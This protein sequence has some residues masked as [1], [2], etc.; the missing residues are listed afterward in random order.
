MVQWLKESRKSQER[1]FDP[2]ATSGRAF[3]G[4]SWDQGYFVQQ[5]SDGGYI[6]LG[7]TKS[8]GAGKSDFWL[9]K[10]CPEE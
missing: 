6:L 7:W 2:G 5:T 8:H 9:V 1:R 10:Y 4:S 3:G